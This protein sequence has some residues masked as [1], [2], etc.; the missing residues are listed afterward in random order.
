MLL[1]L[2]LLWSVLI[3]GS[4]VAPK[5]S[6]CPQTE[7]SQSPSTS[8]ATQ[9]DARP[10]EHAPTPPA[11][12]EDKGPPSSNQPAQSPV[13]QPE[14]KP[15]EQAPPVT[16]SPS[17][18]TS[19]PVSQGAP[20]SKPGEVAPPPVKPEAGQAAAPSAAPK[21]HKIKNKKQKGAAV[22]TNGP[23]KVIVRNGGTEEAFSQLAPDMS[24][25]EASHARET[26]SQLLS[27]TDSNLQLVAT[28]TLN[29]D[30]QAMVEQIRTFMG[31]SNA[32]V[33]AGDLQRGHNLALK[34]LLLSNDLAKH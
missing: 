28:R 23:K 29:Q 18:G 32:A 17:S 12:Q 5:A 22:K 25:E 30:Q 9:N 1:G 34:A 15:A 19:V 14:N 8:P 2:L 24:N 26:T 31:Q 4:F 21:K 3:P 33:K 7:A 13:A 11:P 20:E 6:L 16:S 10:P 27:A